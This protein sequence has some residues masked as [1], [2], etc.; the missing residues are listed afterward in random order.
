[1][2]NELSQEND[3]E[4]DVEGEI[5]EKLMG[6]VSQRS[7]CDGVESFYQEIKA[8][9]MRDVSESGVS[10]TEVF[11][12]KMASRLESCGEIDTFEDAFFEGYFGKKIAR[13]DGSGGDPRDSDGVLSVMICSFKDEQEPVTINA[14]DVRRLFDQ[15]TNFLLAI[16]QADFCSNL[17]KGHPCEGVADTIVTTWSTITKVKLIL[18]TNAIYSARTDAVSAGEIMGVPATYNIWDLSRFYRYES[19]GQAREDLIIHFKNDYGRSVPALAALNSNDEIKS[20]LMVIPGFQLAEI[21]DKWGAR[22]LE[23]NVRSFLQARGKVNQGIRDTIK[24]EPSMFFS[25]NNGLSATAESVEEEVGVDGLR[26]VSVKNF[27]IVNGGQTTASIHAAKRLTPESLADVYVQM[28]LTIVP[29]DRSEEVVPKISQY[30]NS[31]N[32][33]SVADFFS[34]HPFHIRIEEYSRRVLAPARENTNRETKWFY[35]RARGQYLVERAKRSNAERRRFDMEFPKAQLFTK[36]D[37]A[38]AELSFRCMPDT[39]SKG[40]QK[41]FSEFSKQIGD[42]WTKS[43]NRFDGVWYR[44]FVAKLII[45]RHLEKTVARQDWYLGGYRANIITYAIAKLVSDAEQIGLLVDLDAVWREQT[46]SDELNQVL[47]QAA[48]EAAA[49]LT[50]PILGIKNISE[51]AKKQACWEILKNRKIEYGSFFSHCL[52]QRE[53]VK[54]V[55][56]EGRREASLVSGIEAQTKVVNEGGDYWS[57]LRAWGAANKKFSFKEDSILKTCAMIPV[58][59]PTERQCL[60]ALD[61]LERAMLEGYRDEHDI[62]RVRISGWDRQH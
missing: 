33:V 10:P 57:R 22:L 56:R 3:R 28:K 62:P 47:M 4:L 40:A 52:V 15:L 18:I 32:K 27:Q 12:E 23:S 51:W 58:R 50:E 37:L 48:E 14:S 61:I 42:I 43:A 60:S 44:R 24:S 21:Y 5:L 45:F 31:Q 7:G 39:V 9:V 41:N 35:E 26:I 16:H 13:I 36:T 11:F 59:L 54:A 20:Y 38:K 46:V 19:S 25:Y 53:E 29:S 55:E 8:E 1:M 49:V 30:A 34:N 6:L 17:Q 2:S